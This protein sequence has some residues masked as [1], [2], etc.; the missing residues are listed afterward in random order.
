MDSITTI[1]LLGKYGLP[2]NLNSALIFKCNCKWYFHHRGNKQALSDQI[3]CKKRHLNTG[4]A[5]R[6]LLLELQWYHNYIV[7]LE[8]PNQIHAKGVFWLG[9]IAFGFVHMKKR[10]KSFNLVGILYPHANLRCNKQ[11]MKFRRGLRSPHQNSIFVFLQKQTPNAISP[12]QKWLS[13]R[14]G[15]QETSINLKSQKQ[16]AAITCI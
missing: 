10:G 14:V 1:N 3:C 6:K 11:V 13:L 7:A 12:N 2:T 8:T 4:G 9:V 5:V 16:E 15:Q